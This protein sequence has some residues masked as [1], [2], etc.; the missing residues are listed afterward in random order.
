MDPVLVL[1]PTGAGIAL[2]AAAVVLGAPLFSDGLRAVRL[3]RHFARLRAVPLADLPSGFVQVNGQVALESPL[4]APLSNVACA[5]FR[6]EVRVEGR[7]LV[8]R[9]DEH[10][11]FR[12]IDGGVHATVLEQGSRW[13]LPVSAVRTVPADQALSANLTTL[14]ERAPEMHWARRAGETLHFTERTLAVGSRCHVIGYARHAAP[15]ELLVEDEM[16]RTGTDDRVVTTSARRAQAPAASEPDLWLGPGEHLDFLLVSHAEP[17]LSRFSV[18]AWRALGAA[19]GPALSM[20]GLL[21]LASALDFMRASG[22][23]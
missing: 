1:H 14:L 2:A 17:Q 5:G 21:Y 15:V 16:Q 13:D 8:Q 12:L 19:F 11:R 23:F 22:R 20:A 10:R 6:L 4:F 18:P 7:P 3:R 9:V